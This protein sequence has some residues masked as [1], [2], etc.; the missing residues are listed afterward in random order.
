MMQ[1]LDVAGLERAL[2]SQIAEAAALRRKK[3]A[4]DERKRDLGDLS[5]VER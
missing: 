1:P 3:G 4:R 5:A 2:Q